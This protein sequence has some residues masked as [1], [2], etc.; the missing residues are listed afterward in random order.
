M[1]GRKSTK[2]LSQRF[3]RILLLDHH[4]RI[5]GRILDRGSSLVVQFGIP[6]APQR[7]QGLETGNRQQPG[8]D[9]RA[10]FKLARLTPHIEEHL[11]DE[12]LRDLFVPHQPQPET[13]HPDMVPSVKH[14]H[15]EPVALGDPRDQDIV[16]GRMCRTQWPSRKVGRDGMAGGSMGKA[17]LLKLSRGWH[18]SVIYRTEV[19]SLKAPSGRRR[20][21]GVLSRYNNTRQFPS[22]IRVCKLIR[23]S[24]SKQPTDRVTRAAVPS[25]SGLAAADYRKLSL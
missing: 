22:P 11:T 4:F 12:I 21:D 1:L 25:A 15:G 6:P 17:N 14:L 23:A 9:G 13:E 7:R 8:G 20:G 18:G 5:V 10:A 3:T 19:D 24:L 16:R 2:A